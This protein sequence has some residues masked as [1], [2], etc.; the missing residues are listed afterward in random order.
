MIETTLEREKRAE[1]LGILGNIGQTLK[2]KYYYSFRDGN[3]AKIVGWGFTPA[4]Q[5]V[6]Y[7][8]F[9]TGDFDIIPVAKRYGDSKF[10]FEGPLEASVKICKRRQLAEESSLLQYMGKSVLF[11]TVSAFRPGETAE[12]ISWGFT[13]N[14]ESPLL[15]IRFE[16]SE[17]Y[18]GNAHDILKM[19]V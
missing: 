15:L 9:P 17:C 14:Y 3:I 16:N 10:I 13:E 7:I 1:A 6:Y 8:Q 12:I 18:S 2:S 5:A 4:S 19:L 11:Q